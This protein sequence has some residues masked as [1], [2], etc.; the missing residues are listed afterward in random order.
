MLWV[1][2]HPAIYWRPLSLEQQSGLDPP[3][4]SGTHRT[5]GSSSIVQMAALYPSLETERRTPWPH[6]LP[7]LLLASLCCSGEVK[8]GQEGCPL[9]PRPPF[10]HEPC[11]LHLARTIWPFCGDPRAGPASG[12]AVLPSLSARPPPCPPP[13]LRLLPLRQ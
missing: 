7:C 11:C 10:S 9:A 6:H 2:T 4:T 3:G 12:P 5:D 8:S 13:A 1:Q